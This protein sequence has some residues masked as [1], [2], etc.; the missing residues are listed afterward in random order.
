ME[1][2]LSIV[3]T[4]GQKI[5]SLTMWCLFYKSNFSNLRRVLKRKGKVRFFVVFR[6]RFNHLVRL[7]RRIHCIV[8]LVSLV[9]L[10]RSVKN[11]EKKF[12]RTNEMFSTWLISEIFSVNSFHNWLNFASRF[13]AK[14]SVTFFF[15]ICCSSVFSS[16]SRTTENEEKFRKKNE[17]F[18]L[19]EIDLIG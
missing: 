4:L 13:A 17:T 19:T 7:V 12:E 2:I 1:D 5:W 6:R 16:W 15:S 18:Q 9:R 10:R 14:R 8:A 11:E 3:E